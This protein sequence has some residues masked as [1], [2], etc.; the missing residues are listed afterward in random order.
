MNELLRISVLASCAVV[1]VTFV[2]M[3]TGDLGVTGNYVHTTAYNQYTAKEACEVN[4]CI[5]SMEVQRSSQI[6]SPFNTP[7][8]GCMCNG[9]PEYFPLIQRVL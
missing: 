3:I 1:F 8:A 9:K 4:N 5:W 2:V 6:A 7:M